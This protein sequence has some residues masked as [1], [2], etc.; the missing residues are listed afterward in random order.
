MN[1][2]DICREITVDGYEMKVYRD[3]RILGYDAHRK[4][5]NQRKF[6]ENRDGYLQISFYVN[7]IKKNH[8]VHNIVSQCYLGEKPIGYHTIH[9]NNNKLDNRVENLQYITAIDNQRKRQTYNGKKIKGFYKIKNGKFTTKIH[10]DGKYVYLGHF[11]T[12]QDAR[13]AYTDAKLKYHNVIVEN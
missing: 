2:A 5:W 11:D 6:C 10:H 1:E 4:K 9:I 7:K 13:K 8:Y 12:E 3:G